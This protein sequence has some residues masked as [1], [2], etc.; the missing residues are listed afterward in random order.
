MTY[1]LPGPVVT[2]TRKP[3]MSDE[4]I[5]GIIDQYNQGEGEG[6]AGEGG[7]GQPTVRIGPPPDLVEILSVIRDFIASVSELD[8]V[9]NRDANTRFGRNDQNQTAIMVGND[10]VYFDSSTQSYWFDQ[11]GNGTFE[12][13]FWI[14]SD[15]LWYDINNDGSRDTLLWGF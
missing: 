8:S 12:T 11:N 1:V 15:G 3:T 7:G 6:G 5:E 4:E 13:Q 10:V 14:G 2:G 9:G